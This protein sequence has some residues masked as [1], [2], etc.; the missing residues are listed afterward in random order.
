DSISCWLTG[1]EEISAYIKQ[2]LGI[3]FGQTT[4]DDRFTLLPIVC[5][6]DCD[7]GPSMR[8]NTDYHGKLTPER[9]DTILAEY[10]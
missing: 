7:N 5:L 8:V 9:V 1:Y 6:G 4:A 2:K 10:A 3:E